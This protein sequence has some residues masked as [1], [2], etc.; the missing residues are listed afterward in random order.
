MRH[1]PSRPLIALLSVLLGCGGGAQGEAAGGA[2]PKAAPAALMPSPPGEFAP[3]RVELLGEVKGEVLADIKA[4]GA[5]HADVVDTWK[6]SAHAYA[7][8]NNPVY[9]VS[10][11]RLRRETGFTESR[12]CGGC[13]DI[14]LLADGAM[15]AEI[16]PDDPRAHAGL[17]CRACHSITRATLDGN[18]SY[19]L[20]AEEI[21]MPTPG[22]DES[23][24]RHI[25]RAAPKPLRSPELCASCHRAFLDETTG[26]ASH[27]PGMDDYTPW[28]RSLYAGSAAA[29]LDDELEERDCRGCHMPKERATHGDAAAD[30]DGKIASHR[31]LGGHTWL[32]AMRGDE[33]AL[34]LAKR[35]IEGAVSLDFAAAILTGGE[36]VL[37]ADG[38]RVTPG[39]R[40]V[41]DLVLRNLRVGHR[42]PGGTLDAQDSWLEVAVYDAAGKKLAQAGE[43]HA[44]TGEDISAHQ[45]RSYMAGADGKALLLR[46]THRF[47]TPVWNST[48]APREAA[49]VEYAFDVPA[50]LPASALPLK[51]TAR[52]RHRTRN[53]AL[54]GAICDEAKTERGAAFQA[55][56]T[57]YRGEALDPC[58][59]QPI[60]EVAE[61]VVYLGGEA[62]PGEAPKR[63]AWRR[64]YEHG[65]GLSRALQE[66]VG[67]ARPSL[68]KA[69]TLLAPEEKRERAMVL[70]VFAAVAGRQGRTEEAREWLAKAEADAPGHPALAALKGDA[71]S[72]VWRWREAIAP[73]L[74]AAEATPKDPLAWARVALAEGSAG[75]QEAALTHA[76]AGL[77]LE[78]RNADLLRIQALALRA[79][80]SPQE[81]EALEAYLS[82]RPLDEGPRIRGAC[83]AGVPNCALERNPVHVHPLEPVSAPPVR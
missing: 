58:T 45:L 59:P 82:H 16:R 53:L 51:V 35:F 24:R 76:R 65:L 72:Q 43:A 71:L 83:S 78:P 25:E 29:L 74:A 15:E 42:F 30:E 63:A 40:I 13:H 11:E 2:T 23:L 52:L 56:A 64:L 8:F 22:D 27:L 55:S 20:T 4:C 67:E 34:S 37:P 62:P 12:H 48:L 6:T 38:A 50:E 21:P 75:E 61:A 49:V 73:S 9:R 57:I 31:F 26:N 5:C 47:R 39:E 41:L 80:G 68:E 69:L 33:E 54:Q 70:A 14:S 7:T 1:D 46:E 28:S 77:A 10:V 66:R 36:R 32:A 60:T 17:A 79:L 3:S 44:T 18:G 81:E 19:T